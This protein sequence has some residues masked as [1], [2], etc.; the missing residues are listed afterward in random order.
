MSEQF[1]LANGDVVELGDEVIYAG[2]VGV[3]DYLH[4]KNDV[5]RLKMGMLTVTGQLGGTNHLSITAA[6]FLRE[7]RLRQPKLPEAQPEAPEVVTPADRMA[8][9]RAAKAA[10]AQGN[11]ES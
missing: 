6:S 2:N 7:G 8:N 1:T 10:K 3:L 5:C 4:E 9:A 11:A